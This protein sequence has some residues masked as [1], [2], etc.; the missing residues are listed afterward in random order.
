[1]PMSVGGFL[2]APKDS[3]ILLIPCGA[4]LSHIVSSEIFHIRK[5]QRTNDSD[6]ITDGVIIVSG[7]F[8]KRGE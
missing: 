4:W 7:K 8:S 2:A 3:L 5:N 6:T 1:M